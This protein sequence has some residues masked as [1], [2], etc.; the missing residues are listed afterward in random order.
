[1]TKFSHLHV[2]CKVIEEDS[3]VDDIL[4]SHN[5]QKKLDKITKGFEEILRAGGFLLKH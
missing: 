3:Y 2:E 1:M 4:T 5:D